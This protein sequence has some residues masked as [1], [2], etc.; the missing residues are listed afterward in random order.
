VCF[1]GLAGWRAAIDRRAV[2][3]PQERT[4]GG[5]PAYLMPNTSGLNAHARPE[6]FVAHLR[7]ALRQDGRR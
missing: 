5:R 4:I 2:A 3:G 6:D 7:A 1:V